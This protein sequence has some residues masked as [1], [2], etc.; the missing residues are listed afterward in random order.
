MDAVESVLREKMRNEQKIFNRERNPL[1]RTPSF[2]P[3]WKLSHSNLAIFTPSHCRGKH[4]RA[5]YSSYFFVSPCSIR[6]ISMSLP[7]HTATEARP[8]GFGHHMDV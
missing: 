6:P 7:P 5:Q 8:L 4:L 2:V 1:K 3:T